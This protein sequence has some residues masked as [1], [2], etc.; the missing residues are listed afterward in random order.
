M[1]TEKFLVIVMKILSKKA[2]FLLLFVRYPFIIRLTLI[3]E[4]YACG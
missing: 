2:E 1:G 3:M 4:E